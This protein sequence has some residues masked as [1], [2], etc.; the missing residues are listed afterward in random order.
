V[1]GTQL[2]QNV[3]SLHGSGVL[4]A[5]AIVLTLWSGLGVLKVTQTAMNVLWN[6]PYQR[7][8]NFVWSTV[9]AAVMLIVLGVITIA[10][11]AA[12][13]VGAGRGGA[14]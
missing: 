14:L 12:G 9:R 5:L 1:V 13:S 8:L 2:S 11:A 4:L 10:S 6:V 3:H 7:R